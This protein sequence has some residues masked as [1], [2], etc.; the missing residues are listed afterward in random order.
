LALVGNEIEAPGEVIQ[1]VVNDLQRLPL[2]LYPFANPSAVQRISYAAFLIN[3]ELILLPISPFL[4]G[5]TEQRFAKTDYHDINLLDAALVATN[6]TLAGALE[7]ATAPLTL[8]QWVAQGESP[9][10]VL[11]TIAAGVLRKPILIAGDA[12]NALAN[13]LPSPLGGDIFSPDP[14]KQGLVYR[15]LVPVASAYQKFIDLVE[16]DHLLG[17]LVADRISPDPLPTS[18]CRKEADPVVRF[19]CAAS[20]LGQCDEPEIARITVEQKIEDGGNLIG[21]QKVDSTSGASVT[22]TVVNHPKVGSNVR[23]VVKEVR[24]TVRQTVRDVS[25]G[26]HDVVKAVTGLGKKKEAKQEA[27]TQNLNSPMPE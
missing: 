1:A 4:D 6:F 14:A 5:L 2:L 3:N 22:K 16:P 9:V 13:T 24:Q 25:R 8:V 7:A 10:D 18:G 11:R 26:V 20:E 12:A 27:N 15:A 17:T 21:S 19:R 23:A